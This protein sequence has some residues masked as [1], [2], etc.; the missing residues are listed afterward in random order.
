MIRPSGV[1]LGSGHIL[2]EMGVCV[3]RRYGME[4]GPREDQAGVEVCTV[5]KD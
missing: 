4:S 1:W 3:E 5:K 2:L